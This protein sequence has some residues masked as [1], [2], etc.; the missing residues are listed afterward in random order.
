[1]SPAKPTTTTPC[2]TAIDES[3]EDAA[4]EQGVAAGSRMV[5]CPAVW[6]ALL[7]VVGAALRLGLLVM[8]WPV[9]NSDEATMGL[10]AMHITDGRAFPVFMDGQSYMGT[11]EAYLAAGLFWV[12]G[13]SLVALRIPMLLMF[14]V[15]LV[16]IYVL[17]RRLYGT[18][19]ALVSVGV[20]TL[21]SREMYGHE[22]VAQGAVPETLLAGTLLLLLG[23]RLL[24]TADHDGRAARRQWLLA[25]WGAAAML[26]LWSTV[27]VAPFVVTSA[28]LLCLAGRRR[29]ASVPVGAWALGGGLLVGAVPWLLH[30]LTRPFSQS[31]VAAV[32]GMYTS[33][34]TGLNGARS[35]GLV[36]QVTNTVTTSL[37]YVSGGSAIAHPHSP[38]A[39]YAGTPGSWHPPTD[40]AMATLWGVALIVLWAAGVTGTVRMLRYHRIAVRQESADDSGRGAVERARLHGRLAMLAAAGLTVAAFAASATPG[41]SP[42]NNIRYIIGALVATPAVMGPLWR[43]RS[44][45]PKV[46]RL[47]RPAV[48]AFVAL[49]L[50]IGTAQAYRDAAHSSG[51]DASRQLITA[52][53]QRGITHIYGGYLDCNRL[54][55]ISDEEIICAVLFQNPDGSLRPGLDRYLPYRAAAGADRQ[56]AY[57]FRSGD[58]RN[59]AL[60]RSACRWKSRWQLAGYQIWQPAQRC[61]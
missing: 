28:V 54:T 34:G 2:A 43:L 12:F 38:P 31:S 11:A 55:F 19:V 4:S 1:V 27:L 47:L 18:Q 30:D 23:H 6:L 29:P 22:L 21:G 42:A 44:A 56:A 16:A 17:A 35:P 39:W 32:V 60:A 24:E 5:L 13:P 20:L 50:V 25:G 51:E 7:L 52:L 36:S 40:S 53:R 49:T 37:A 14:L 61:L 59:V 46:G 15:F 33:G 48:L 9:S 3:V 10:M 26:G 58:P 8:E 41:V 57:V 45:V